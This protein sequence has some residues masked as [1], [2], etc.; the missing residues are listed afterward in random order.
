M[1][2]KVTSLLRRMLPEISPETFAKV[3]GV[4]NLP[5]KDFSIISVTNKDSDSSNSFRSGILDQLLSIIAKALTLQVKIKGKNGGGT[6]MKEVS[7]IT[8]AATISQSI[9]LG[10]QWWLRGYVNRKLAEVIISLIKDMALVRYS[11]EF[12]SMALTKH[13][14]VGEVVWSLGERNKGSNSREHLAPDPPIRGGKGTKHLHQNSNVMAGF[15]L[16]LCLRQRPRWKVI[17]RWAPIQ[18]HQPQ[19]LTTVLF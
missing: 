2:L 18:P 17:I 14:F 12:T 8:L 11:S 4:T 9:D 3:T 10:R 7:T 13:F 19:Y 15:G 16:T 1:Y 6:Q 5:P